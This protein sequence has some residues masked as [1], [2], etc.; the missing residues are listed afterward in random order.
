MFL[1]SVPEINSTLT[2]IDK[3]IVLDAYMHFLKKLV[4]C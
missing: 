4:N 3:I 1:Q 2:I